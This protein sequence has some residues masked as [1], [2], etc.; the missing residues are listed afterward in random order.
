[1]TERGSYRGR[2]VSASGEGVPHAGPEAAV[3]QIWILGAARNYAATHDWIKQTVAAAKTL[4]LPDEEK[5]AEGEEL[6]G[7]FVPMAPAST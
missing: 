5:P 4:S 3:S 6:V 2:R 7:A 1:M